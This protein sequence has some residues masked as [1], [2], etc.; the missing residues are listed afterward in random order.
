MMTPLHLA[1]MQAFTVAYSQS[2]FFGKLIIWSL[3]VL[4]I[5][6]WIVLIYKIWQAQQVKKASF[7]FQAIIEQNKEKLLS[8]DPADLSSLLNPRIPH[9][10][11]QIFFV[12]KNK[13]IE[14]LNKKL[15]F[16]EQVKASAQHEGVYLSPSDLELLEQHV[17][18]TISAQCKLLEKHL[19]VL[20][21]IVTLAP[22]LGLLGTVWGILV[23]F[24]E[25][26][27]GTGSV[28]SNTAILGGLSTALSTTVL[29]LIIAIPALVSYNYLKNNLKSFSSDMEDFLYNL[30]SILELQYRKVDLS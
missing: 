20:S 11:A 30:M 21:T 23:T 16:I 29:G 18:T 3:V 8:I 2:D 5:I 13:T 9:P 26:H 10:F 7:T 14:T 6:C 28:G 25:L 19:F 4:S 15:F 1:S 24:S 22:F 12:L 27:S 17:S